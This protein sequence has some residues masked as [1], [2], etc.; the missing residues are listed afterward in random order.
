MLKST[1]FVIPLADQMKMKSLMRQ[2]ASVLQDIIECSIK[3]AERVQKEP[4]MTRPIRSVSASVPT[5]KFGL[6]SI[7]AAFVHGELIT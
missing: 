3:S 6:M 1:Q 2:V 7:N 5:T 4:F